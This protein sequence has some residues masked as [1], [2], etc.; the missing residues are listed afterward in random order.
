M[1]YS[2]AGGN[3][4][5]MRDYYKAYRKYLEEWC[6]G[7]VDEMIY[8]EYYLRTDGGKYRDGFADYVQADKKFELEEYLPDAPDRIINF[9]DVGSGPFYG[10]GEQGR[11]A[12]DVCLEL[13]IYVRATLDRMKIEY[14]GIKTKTA[15]EYVGEYEGEMILLT[16]HGK[17]EEIK[18]NLLSHGYP[19]SKLIDISE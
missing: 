13:G 18:R 10:M 5:S 8:W 19:E 17:R 3:N 4:K 14:R 2:K 12:Y 9:A 11:F 7:L 16:V 6:D 1:L 15:G